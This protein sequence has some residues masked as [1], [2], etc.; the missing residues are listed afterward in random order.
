M[1]NEKTILICILYTAA[2]IEEE[3]DQKV[4]I[5][6]INTSL[7]IA[8]DIIYYTY[9]RSKHVPTF[10]YYDGIL[11][12]KLRVYSNS[13][14][15]AYLIDEYKFEQATHFHFNLTLK[16]VFCYINK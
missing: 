6:Y 16:T 7:L 13:C 15:C 11:V 3:R 8:I 2:C 14:A 5:L 1:F 12:S 10:T 9:C 4:I